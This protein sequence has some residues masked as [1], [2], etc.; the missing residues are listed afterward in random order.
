MNY[1]NYK[2]YLIIYELDNRTHIQVGR[3]GGFWFPEGYYVYVGKDHRN[4][5][6]RVSRHISKNKKPRW[7]IDYF[8]YYALPIAMRLIPGEND[9]DEC[10]I[11]EQ[12]LHLGGEILISKF[13]SSDCGC[14]SHLIYFKDL[15]TGLQEFLEGLYS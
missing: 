13:G 4:I 5:R 7:H 2:Y 12:L 3:L 11:S 6:A 9:L 8:S 14:P 10:M 15:Q 1:M